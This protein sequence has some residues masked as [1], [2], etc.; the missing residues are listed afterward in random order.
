MSPPI[1]TL[2]LKKIINFFV[3]KKQQL[4]FVQKFQAWNEKPWSSKTKQLLKFSLV[5]VIL[6]LWLTSCPNRLRLGCF[7]NKNNVLQVEM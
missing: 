7:E 1:I 2:P 5:N 3:E 4:L 6:H